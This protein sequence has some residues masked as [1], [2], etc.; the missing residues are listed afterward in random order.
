[1]TTAATALTSHLTGLKRD[2][3]RD[4]SAA[5]GITI[6]ISNHDPRGTTKNGTASFEPEGVE[7]I[8]P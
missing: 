4:N 8:F 1:M 6:V 7:T 2:S 3:L 5:I